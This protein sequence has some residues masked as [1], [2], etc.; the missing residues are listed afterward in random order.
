MNKK[1]LNIV[2]GLLIGGSSL[3]ANAGSDSDEE[4]YFKKGHA[5]EELKPKTPL[6]TPLNRRESPYQTDWKERPNQKWNGHS[7]ARY[8]KLSPEF[9]KTRRW[10]NQDGSD[11]HNGPRMYKDLKPSNENQSSSDW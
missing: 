5:W 9:F 8:G 6:E 10:N 3:V 1:T 11:M 4:A 7:G 2:Y